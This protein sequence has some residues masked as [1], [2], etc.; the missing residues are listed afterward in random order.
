MARIQII[1]R[2]KKTEGKITLR[3]RLRDGREIDLYHK[4]EIE[5]DLSDLSKFEADGTPKKRANFNRNLHM[6]I[7]ERISLMQTV[8][9]EAVKE[10]KTLTNELFESDIDLHLHPE[11]YQH[12][13][14]DP[15]TRLLLYRFEKM[16]NG[17]ELITKDGKPI[18]EGRKEHYK[19]FLRIMERYLIIT[20]Q[21]D[22]TFDKVDKDF[23]LSFRDFMINEYKFA[24]KKKW[25]YLYSDMR[26][27]N[28]PSEERC[29][30][31]VSMKIKMLQA[32][33]KILDAN[34]E[35]VKNP[36]NKFTDAN[37]AALLKQEYHKPI[38]LTLDEVRSILTTNVPTTLQATKDA[39]LL[40][41]ALGCRI[42]DFK[43]MNMD[44]IKVDKQGIPYIAYAAQ[45]T[46]KSTKTPLVR[47]AFDI[48]RRT[49]F[50]LPVLK[51]VSGKSGFNKKIKDLLKYCGIIREV[52]TG[53][54]GNKIVAS[55]I[56]EE[57][58]TKLGRKTNVTLLSRIQINSTIAGLH[59]EGSDAV[60]HYYDQ[61]LQDL[62][63]LMSRAFGEKP[64]K[65]NKNLEIMED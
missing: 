30:N 61:S 35:I 41:I 48:I 36:F 11:K 52:E 45:K 55:P 18:S 9:D 44:Y 51:Y 1:N 60:K 22:I 64:Y 25:A 65:V 14:A 39:F 13:E 23:I 29:Q 40:Q 54:D 58:S 57:A 4:S 21:E 24:E 28:K 2:T 38:S 10:G 63:I 46:G 17:N 6:A 43:G 27:N 3:F 20:K 31:T 33:F 32:F 26:T 47:F 34:D 62:F 59:A 5:A 15:S 19:V 42:S 49:N 37:H 56:Y 53:I 50:N 12:E 16:V 7:K 8:Y